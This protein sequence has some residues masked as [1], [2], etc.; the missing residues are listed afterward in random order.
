MWLR[1]QFS[2]V[3]FPFGKHKMSLKKKKE[4]EEMRALVGEEK[5]GQEGGNTPSLLLE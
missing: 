1:L 3:H 5:E 2:F 4:G